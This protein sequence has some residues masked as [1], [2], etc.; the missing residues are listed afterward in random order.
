[1]IANQLVQQGQ[2]VRFIAFADD[3]DPLRKVY[4]FL[5]DSYAEWVGCP[6]NII[7]DPWGCHDNYATHYMAQLMMAFEALELRPEVLRSS[8]PYKGGCFAPLVK[9]F[10]AARIRL[11]RSFRKQPQAT[12][13]TCDQ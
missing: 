11:P 13:N 12:W 8:E 5:P 1:L 7:P 9:Q 10:L 4:P 3:L 6:L 2:K